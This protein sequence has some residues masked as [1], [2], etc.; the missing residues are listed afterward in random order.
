[1]SLVLA[2]C[3]SCRAP[4]IPLAPPPLT[5]GGPHNH[6]IGALAVA[7]K[8]AAT[9]AFRTYQQQVVANARALAAR[10]QHHGYSVCTGG[11]D[12]HL[13]L[14]DLRPAG[15]SG[16]KMQASCACALCVYVC[17]CGGARS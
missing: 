17:A 12:N 9:P 4:T 13:V 8:H 7:L 3:P 1:M 10:L 11:T 6:Q 2:P 15:V 14:W 5:Q 16:G